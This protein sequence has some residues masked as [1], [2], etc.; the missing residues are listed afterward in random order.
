MIVEQDR[1]A[2]AKQDFIKERAFLKQVVV[3]A[4]VYERLMA[5]KDFL[6]F[7]GDLKDRIEAHKTNIESCVGMIARPNNPI[8][9]LRIA[10]IVVYHQTQKE[11]C[12]E[13]VSMPLRTMNAKAEAME[14]VSEID[15]LEKELSN[16]PT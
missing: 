14:R 11:L 3:K 1:V 15:K 9:R 16:G 5:N 12:E 13:I 10:D 6:E 4:E 8:R 2:Q 7:V